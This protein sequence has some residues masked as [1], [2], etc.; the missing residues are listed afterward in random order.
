MCNDFDNKGLIDLY[1][2][3]DNKYFQYKL[4]IKDRR[5]KKK[6]SWDAIMTMGT[7]SI[8]GLE[9]FILQAS[10]FGYSE[11]SA[12]EFQE[13]VKY[14]KYEE[15]KEKLYEASSRAS[16]VIGKNEVNTLSASLD[17]KS[18]WGIY[19]ESLRKKKFDDEAIFHIE[20]TTQKILRNLHGETKQDE[21]VRGLVVGNVQSGKTA[22]MGALMAMAADSGFNMFIILSGTIE[23]LRRQ[24]QERLFKDLRSDYGNISWEMI[25]QPSLMSTTQTQN[26][27]FEED[28]R[29]RDR[30]FTVSLKVKS[31]LEKLI[32][33]IQKD[34]HKQK[35][36]K[37]LVIDDEAD[38]AGINTNDVDEDERRTINRLIINLVQNK[39]KNGEETLGQYKAMNYIGYTATPYANVL[40]EIKEDSLFPFDFIATLD[41][42]NLYFGPQQIFGS[43]STPEFTGMNIIRTIPKSELK[44]IKEIHKGENAEM[45]EELAKA[46]LWFIDCVAFMRYYGSKKPVSC[47]VHTSLK[48]G[49]HNQIARIISGWFET[50]C[51]EDEIIDLCRDVWEEE[52]SRFT[53][54][55]FHESYESYGVPVEKIRDYPPFDRIES[56]I[57]DIVDTGIERVRLNE[58]EDD[59]KFNRG[60]HLC[61]D[62]S[63][64]NGFNENDEYIRLMYPNETNNP[65]YATAFIVIGGQTLSRGL[66]LEGLVSTYF[67]RQT[68]QADTLMQMGRWFGYRRGYELLPRIW[69]TNRVIDQF[70][71]LTEIDEELRDTIKSMMQAGNTPGEYGVTVKNSP[72]LNF[73]RLTAKNRMQSADEVDLDY[74]GARKQTHIFHDN[75]T[76]L[77][78]NIK[79]SESFYNYLNQHI[80]TKEITKKRQIIFRNVDYSVIEMYLNS[81]SF[82]E[83][84]KAFSDI[85]QFTE[86]L[87]RMTNENKISNWNVIFMSGS[88]NKKWPFINIP[89]V[90]RAKKDLTGKQIPGDDTI[91]IGAITGTSDYLCDVNIDELTKRKPELAPYIET[92]SKNDISNVN[93][94]RREAGLGS[95]P[96]LIIYCIDKDSKGTTKNRID[97]NAKN[98]VIGLAVNIPGG[99]IGTGYAT[100]LRIDLSKNRHNID[101]GADIDE[102]SVS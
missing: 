81:Y 44:Q 76:I 30:Y 86:W 61:I 27:H 7:G 36:M 56:F 32:E 43:K 92:V 23:N 17:P 50:V 85:E 78:D 1:N 99:R 49:D 26:L 20:K 82:H 80:S 77:R 40:N 94:I 42:S 41:V 34:P 39:T 62:N 55:D 90:I 88:S 12:E 28:S 102:D 37:I 25:E 70:D 79:A 22:N 35:E 33:W 65:G 93:K 21:P 73:L 19:K 51:D 14:L 10:A 66:T 100:K 9:N 11:I 67:L 96:Q 74:S 54:E 98:N 8:E 2:F 53:K 52:T 29:N 91:R 24:T 4:L 71:F 60:I 48:T 6:Q 47:L 38:Q 15:E 5:N 95:V 68:K 16:S 84:L 97:L 89:M 13:L 87:R 75:E 46:L 31:R 72:M 58:K 83:N 3:N 69:M 64:N 101:E 45:P 63:K 57:E 59:F 18:A